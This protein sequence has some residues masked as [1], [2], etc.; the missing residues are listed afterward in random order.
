VPGMQILGEPMLDALHRRAGGEDGSPQHLAD[1]LQLG[2]AQIVLEEW[3]RP[4]QWSSRS[5][6][7][8]MIGI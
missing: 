3:D 7:A 5:P 4:G 2:L 8:E 6:P 1:R